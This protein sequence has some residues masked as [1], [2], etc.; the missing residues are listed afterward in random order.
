MQITIN[1]DETTG[2]MSVEAE[3][4]EPYMCESLEECLA[5]VEALI[6]GEPVE[7]TEE[8]GEMAAP[9]AEMPQGD[10]AAMWDEE[11]KKRPP[12]PSLMR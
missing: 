10:M 8:A 9:E 3:G 6:T 4:Q 2:Q 1:I 11:A 7:N 5:H 12:N